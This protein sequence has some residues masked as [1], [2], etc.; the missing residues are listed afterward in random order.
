MRK[1][2]GLLLFSGATLTIPVVVSTAS[3]HLKELERQGIVDKK[4]DT[5]SGQ[6]PYP[7]VYRVSPNFKAYLEMLKELEASRS[8]WTRIAWVHDSEDRMHAILMF[9]LRNHIFDFLFTLKYVIQHEEV[10]DFLVELHTTNYLNTLW[11]L[12]AQLKE[13]T[14]SKDQVDAL[15]STVRREIEEEAKDDLIQYHVPRFKEE[16]RDTASSL[17][18]LYI[19]EETRRKAEPAFPLFLER[20]GR[21]AETMAS[22]DVTL[23]QLARLKDD[24]AAATIAASIRGLSPSWSL[25]RRGR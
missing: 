18:K 5:E 4:V 16:N 9:A 13:K 10:A 17:I 1:I 12:V 7:A 14:L 15:F 6:Y 19:E 3:K 11:N 8:L 20:I 2:R 25:I 21:E 24:P 23:A 22:V